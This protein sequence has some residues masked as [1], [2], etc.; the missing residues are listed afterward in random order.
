LRE[1]QLRRMK[2]SLKHA[3]EKVPAYRKK[4]DAAGVKPK[5]LKMLADLAK[6]PFTAKADLR[7]NY[8]FGMFAVPMDRIVRIHASSGTTGKPTVVG[9]TQKD[10]D[11]GRTSWRAHSARPGR[12]PA[13]RCI[14]RTATA[15]SPAAWARTTARRSSASP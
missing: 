15:F 13:T 3:Y 6:F 14:T 2:W 8:P 5:D 9:Y 7:E 10:I 1:L 12:A 4:F 11:T